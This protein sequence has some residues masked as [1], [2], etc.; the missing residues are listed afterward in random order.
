MLQKCM[1]S[2]LFLSIITTYI[3]NNC[4]KY[5]AI[6]FIRCYFMVKQCYIDVL[7]VANHD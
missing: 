2:T 6:I 3:C 1:L 5:S 4:F 7:S